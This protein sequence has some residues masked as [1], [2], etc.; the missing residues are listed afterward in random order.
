VGRREDRVKGEDR[1][2]TGRERGREGERESVIQREREMRWEERRV[3]G[4][5]MRER[6][7]N[8]TFDNF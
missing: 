3:E 2:E 6:M 8:I 4:K 1:E 7:T 5:D